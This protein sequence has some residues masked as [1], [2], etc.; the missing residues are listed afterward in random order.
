MREN[1]TAATAK[2]MKAKNVMKKSDRGTYDYAV[3]E[4]YSFA[5]G[6]IP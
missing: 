3:M 6:M 2:T 1:W 4:K 5:S